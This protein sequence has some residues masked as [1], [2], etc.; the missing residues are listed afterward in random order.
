MAFSGQNYIVP[1]APNKAYQV[2]PGAAS[3]YQCD[4]IAF[5]IPAFCQ[6]A[7]QSSARWTSLQGKLI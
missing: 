2:A 4:Y 6:R 3:R 5:L 1:D 7:K